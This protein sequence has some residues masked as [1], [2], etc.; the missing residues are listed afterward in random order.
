MKI[1]RYIAI[2]AILISTVSCIQT[3]VDIPVTN[4]K[5]IQIIGH[6]QSFSDRNVD[7]RALKVGDE[8]N[9]EA[10]CLVVFNN[11][12]VCTRKEYQPGN[13]T[14]TLTTD[15]L[16]D[17][18]TLCMFAN[19]PDPTLGAGNTLDEFKL[20]ACP[21]TTVDIPEL[22]GTKCFPMYGEKKI[23]G[24]LDAVI[25]IPLT[26]LYAK[27]VV[28][29]ISNPDQTVVGNTPAKFSLTR[30]EVHNVVESVDFVGGTISAKG[31]NG[32]KD[33]K[34]VVLTNVYTASNIT[35][36]VAQADK[37]ASFFF[38]LPERFLQA[39]TAADNY[40]Y[41]FR[42]QSDGT[43]RPEDEKYRQRYKPC[44]VEGKNATF[45]RFFGEYIDHQGHNWNVSYDIYVGNDN[46]SNFDIE[47]NVQYN[48]YVTIK[49]IATSSDATTGTISVDHRVNIAR[50]N[51]II[52]NFRREALLDSHYE[53]RPLRIRKNPN[54]TGNYDDAK[55]KVEVVFADND[56]AK[57]N[58]AKRWIGIERSFGNGV[59]QT[60]SNNTYLVDSDLATNRK[61]S[62]GKRKYFT[63]DL[64]TTTLAGNK[65]I[66]VPISDTDETVWIYVDECTEAGDDVRAAKIKL[67]VLLNGA[68][69]GTTEYHINQ[70]KLFPVTYNGRTYHIEYHEEYLH[71]YDV[72]DQYG[73]TE[74]EGMQ[75]GLPNTKF[76]DTT[77]AILMV[78]GSWGSVDDAVY[79]KLQS[80]TP[81]YDFYLSRDVDIEGLYTPSGVTLYHDRNGHSF[82]SKIISK[83]SIPY[84][85]MGDSAQS[86]VQYCNNKNK[87]G[88]NKWYLPAI[89]EIEEIVMSQYGDGQF[90][91]SRF[92]DFRAKNYWSCQPAY[93]N[94]FIFVERLLGDR[95]GWYMFEN[96]ER[97]RATSVSYNG[98]GANDPQNYSKKTSGMTGYFKYIDADYSDSANWFRGELSNT[99]EHDVEVGKKFSGSNQK[100]DISETLTAPVYDSCALMRTDY[101][102]VRCV[103]KK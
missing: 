49:G 44:L 34:T 54:A 20:I 78:V 96:E 98:L 22:N 93:K 51:P 90:S 72:E 26:A 101:A 61:N 92:P 41:P 7:S 24:S 86:A 50:V 2:L 42:K 94:N 1:F 62:A 76:S 31:Q 81:F 89:D 102:R 68:E 56:E 30:Y 83:A 15:D 69:I 14:F 16:K 79:S 66:E 63:T 97:A 5:T 91:Y 74:Y 48:N 46:Y 13:P 57:T 12:N 100:Y 99:E 33:D 40:G 6:V 64:T 103:R 18:Y 47:R 84:N 75:W 88:E 43:I 28:N 87:Q 67:T 23:G 4:G 17:G 3:D 19:I 36:D 25:Q 35:S 8:S 77:Y 82:C 70:R 52:V 9:V 85:H 80:Y 11:N 37:E 38:Y 58:D 10:L 73:Q 60:T 55:I 29:I 65:T 39:G 53:V 95:W 27:V 21:V 59:T 32:G 45:V 71:N